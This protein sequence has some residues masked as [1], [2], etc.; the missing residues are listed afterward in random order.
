MMFPPS[1]K[2][3]QTKI[4]QYLK[5]NGVYHFKTIVTNSSGTP[6]IIACHN[7]IFYGIEVKNHTNKMSKLQELRKK[8]INNSGG[9]H[10]L[11]KSL[12]DVA[13]L[14]SF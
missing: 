7:G 9:I 4:L 13:N 11:A 1:E 10:I 6:D 12:E 3:I 2:S 5:Q 14:I 8:Q